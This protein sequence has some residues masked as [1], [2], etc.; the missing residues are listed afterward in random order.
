MIA[1]LIV[2]LI[3]LAC[4]AILY[5]KSTVL[6]ALATLIIAVFASMVAFGFFELSASFFIKEGSRS[7]YP[8]IVPLAQPLCFILLFI[9]TFALLQTL[10]ALLT[11]EPVDL[12]FYPELVGRIICGIFLGL[13]LSGVLLTTLAMAPLPN[14]YPYERFDESRPDTERPTKVLLN[15]DGFA[16]GWFNMVSDGSFRA[17][18]KQSRRS[19]SALHPDFIDQIFLNRHNYGEKIPLAS[20]VNSI[21]LPTKTDENSQNAAWFAP[22]NI[23]DTKGNPIPATKNNK[24]LIIVRV[25]IKKMAA[26]ARTFTLSQLRAVCKREN[27]AKY[28]SAGK[29]WNSYPIGYITKPNTIRQRPLNDKIEIDYDDFKE[30][31]LWID[32]AFYIPEERI[33]TFI[34]FKLNSIAPVLAAPVPAGDAPPPVSFVDITDKKAKNRKP[35]NTYDRTYNENPPTRRT[36]EQDN[37][38]NRRKFGD[39]GNL[40]YPPIDE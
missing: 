34:E 3:I 20:M 39:T 7:D 30:N 2:V 13:I 29:A 35:D 38:K 31:V 22:T 5:L 23:K 1:G 37:S 26:N 16:A 6:K 15:A 4:A 11:K 17:I 32:F 27:L 24:N 21:T 9:L 18:R 8:S 14:K 19:F 12:G 40:I 28:P 36:N 10:A 33:P 25:G